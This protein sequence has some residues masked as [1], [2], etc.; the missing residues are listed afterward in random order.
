MFAKVVETSE[1]SSNML[2]FLNAE[3]VQEIT[4][5]YLNFFSEK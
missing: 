5:N 2:F 3:Y 4:F 1:K